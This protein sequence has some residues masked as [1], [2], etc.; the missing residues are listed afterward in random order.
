M[1]GLP[2]A[3]PPFIRDVPDINQRFDVN[4]LGNYAGPPTGTLQQAVDQFIPYIEED[5]RQAVINALQHS[6]AFADLRC[7]QGAADPA[8]EF[9]AASN[10]YSRQDVYKPFNRWLRENQ[11][12]GPYEQFTHML[13]YSS[14]YMR[15]MRNST[16]LYRGITG[17]AN[18]QYV[19][20]KVYTWNQFSSCSV[21]RPTALRFTEDCLQP[22]GTMFQ[23][24]T[25]SAERTMTAW[26]AEFAEEQ[27]ECE[28]IA[29]PHIVF[30]C[31]WKGFDQD[32]N[33]WFI[34]I[35]E[36]DPRVMLPDLF[37][38]K[39]AMDD[40]LV[41]ASRLPLWLVS[42]HGH[43]TIDAVYKCICLCTNCLFFSAG[44]YGI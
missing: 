38:N 10:L 3:D 32:L 2:V 34:H 9:I 8:R 31:T 41:C 27:L 11:D 21:D 35:E 22:I 19:V 33:C 29:M 4:H 17:D 12:P 14:R 20:G 13:F 15:P 6:L 7:P 43:A 39:C 36:M 25:R 18:E 26:L 24:R 42:H 5:N 30:R 40:G 23:L 1:E 28:V 16:T 44:A 37:L